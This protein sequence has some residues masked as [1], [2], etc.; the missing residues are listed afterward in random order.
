MNIKLSLASLQLFNKVL[1]LELD[2]FLHFK[3][4]RKW[5]HERKIDVWQGIEKM[6]HA[7]CFA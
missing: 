3:D 1:T 6:V 7:K 2:K 4:Y 5:K